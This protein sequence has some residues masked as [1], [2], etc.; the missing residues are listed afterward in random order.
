MKIM[1]IYS[2]SPK[3]KTIK[4]NENFNIVLG[5]IKY[6]ND[7]DKDS[8]NLGKSSLISLIDFLFLKE[9]NKE[10]F[11]RLKEFTSHVFFMEIKRNNESYLTIRRPVQRN[12]KISFKLH[13]DPYQN[14]ID[15]INWDY[16]DLGIKA[17]NDYENAVYVL[18][19]FLKFDVI[20]KENY[21]KTLSYFFRSQSDYSNVFKLSKF[22]GNDVDWKP[23]LF[24]LLGFDSKH[25]IKKYY[26][27]SEKNKK[28][29]LIEQIEK[30]FKISE[31]DIDKIKGI[32]DIKNQE[33]KQT[34]EWLDKF[35][36]YAQ[37]NKIE[38]VLVQDIEER[39]SKLNTLKYDLDYE[40][41]EIDKSLKSNITYDIEDITELYKE[42][43][44]YFPD[45]LIKEYRDLI[46]FNEKV[47]V[48]RKQYLLKSLELK[49]QQLQ[50]IDV[51]LLDLNE[52]RKRYM[53]NFTQSDTFEKYNLYRNELIN[54]ERD[55]ARYTTELENVDVIKNLNKEITKIDKGI[56][57]TT[58][59]IKNQIEVG[60]DTYKSIRRDFHDFVKI[61]LNHEAMISLSVNSN[62]NI[63][64]KDSIVDENNQITAQ[65]DG[66]TYKKIL[67]ACFD[68]ALIKNYADKNFY[69]TVYHDG[70][71]ESLDPRKQKQYLEL[72][73]RI[74]NEYGIQYILTALKSDIPA[75]DGNKYLPKEF[76]I[77]VTLSDDIDDSGRLFGFSF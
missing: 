20:P 71:L 43:Q 31:E 51:E 73:R 76:E 47:F 57:E 32:I 2:N 37:D 25:M 16:E 6:A 50:N 49:K 61:I 12:T 55:I 39:I 62:G 36:F 26:L 48:E 60:N 24:E 64:F 46:N 7:L 59:N 14:F 35:D 77:A 5:D 18:N 1:Q 52:Q 41:S 58:N 74:S 67:C 8:H 53:S 22:K 68:L 56:E 9:L 19:N 75:D 13:N 54:I 38:K 10:H 4:F 30:E 29:S 45:N 66:H 63:E 11:L 70:C 23:T 17:S 21:R 40:I 44:I 69:K 42:F 33:R 15:E 3:F 27:D 28:K 34:L 65:N 72:V